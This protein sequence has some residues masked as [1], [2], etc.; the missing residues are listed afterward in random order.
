MIVLLFLVLAM[1]SLENDYVRVCHKT[2]EHLP[3]SQVRGWDKKVRGDGRWRIQTA[4]CLL[5][6]AELVQTHMTQRAD[7]RSKQLCQ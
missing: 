5:R 3:S 4:Q 7:L 2:Q 1:S 6:P